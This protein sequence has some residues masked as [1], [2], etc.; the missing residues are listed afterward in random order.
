MHGIVANL[1]VETLKILF[2]KDQNMIVYDVVNLV[3]AFLIFTEKWK[4]AFAF[5]GD[6]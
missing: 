4:F 5:G 2:S 3:D 6:I 1:E